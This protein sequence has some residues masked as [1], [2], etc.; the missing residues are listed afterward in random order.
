MAE[1]FLSE[2]RMFGFSFAPKGWALCNGQ[3]LPIAQN[4]ALFALLGTTYGGNGTT[5]F[6]LPDLRGRTPT[7]FGNGTLQGDAAG[8]E[9]VTLLPAQ[10]PAHTHQATGATD[11][12]NS[13]NYDDTVFTTATDTI[14]QQPSNLY[15]PANALVA[16]GTSMTATGG[17]QPHDNMQPSLVVNFCIATVG[18]FPSRN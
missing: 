10:M 6:A 17:S 9:N 16:L 18:T 5:T 7:H 8:V 1:P 15:G 14:T 2:V 13:R 12:F 3:L 4:Q 11:A